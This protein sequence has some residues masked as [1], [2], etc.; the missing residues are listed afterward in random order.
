MLHLITDERCAE[1]RSPG[2]PERPER[3]VRTAARLRSQ[4]DVALTWDRPVEVGREALLRAHSAEHLQRVEVATSDFDGDTPAHAGIFGHAVRGVGGALKGLDLARKGEGAFSLLRPP[5]HHATRSRAMGF[6]YLSTIAIAVLEALETGIGKVAVFDFDVHHGNGSEAI[7]MNRRGAWFSSVHQYPC[8]PGTGTSDVGD[9]CFN[10]P[11][12]PGFPREDYRKVLLR[13]L[14]KQASFK[15]DLLGIS[16]GFDAYSGDP[17]AQETLEADDYYWLGQQIKRLGI[18]AFNVLEGGYS[19]DLPE[20]VL[21]Y[22]RGL[23]G[24]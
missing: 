24:G 14:E 4:N 1:Y 8:Y 23:S 9:N 17:I 20:L 6:C 10:F 21:S 19:S 16:A 22:L 7:L 2:H 11:V 12:P 5:G 13:A 15:P 18:P 3:V